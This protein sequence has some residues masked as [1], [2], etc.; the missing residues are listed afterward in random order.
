MCACKIHPLTN[1]KQLFYTLERLATDPDVE[2]QYGVGVEIG[3]GVKQ[4]Q[5]Q[6]SDHLLRDRRLPNEVVHDRSAVDAA[7]GGVGGEKDNTITSVIQQGYPNDYI[8]YY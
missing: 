7:Q 6:I 4:L 1:Q 3:E 8:Y 5:H 2:V